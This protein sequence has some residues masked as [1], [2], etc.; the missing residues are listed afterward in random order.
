MLLSVPLLVS[1]NARAVVR[2]LLVEL[3]LLGKKKK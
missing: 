1:G 3:G 2:V